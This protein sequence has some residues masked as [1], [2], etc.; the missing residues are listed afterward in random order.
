MR[1]VCVMLT[2]VE[3]ASE[4]RTR[5]SGL[6]KE[7]AAVQKRAQAAGP[8]SFSSFRTLGRPKADVTEGDVAKVWM[9]G[10]VW[11]CACMF[12]LVVITPSLA[13]DTLCRVGCEGLG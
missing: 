13:F 8:M 10:H 3:D 6:H 4:L 7:L 12:V 5:V 11:M 2:Q 9:C 1:C